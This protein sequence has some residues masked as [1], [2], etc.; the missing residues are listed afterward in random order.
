VEVPLAGDGFLVVEVSG[1]QNLFPVLYPSEQVP[2]RFEDALD[3]V[4]GSI[5]LGA[6]PDSLFPVLVKPA[7]PLAFTNPIWIA[8]DGDGVV[9]PSLLLPSASEQLVSSG[10]APGPPGANQAQLGP[11]PLP[12]L[13]EA[14]PA[15]RAKLR[16]MPRWL[17]PTS[18]PRDVRRLFWHQ[19]REAH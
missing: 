15:A 9:T 18:D 3:A 16:R 6:D 14:S 19:W 4:G 13:R 8:A 5:G 7:R 1:E 10:A 12:S 17:W 2:I 11:L